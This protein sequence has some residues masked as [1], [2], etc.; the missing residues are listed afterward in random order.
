METRVYLTGAVARLVV[1]SIAAATCC[2]L[3]LSDDMA[4]DAGV[5]S[6]KHSISSASWTS[7]PTLKLSLSFWLAYTHTWLQY[8]HIWLQD[9]QIHISHMA[10]L[11]WLLLLSLSFMYTFH[12]TEYAGSWVQKK[13]QHRLLRLLIWSYLRGHS[14][15]QA[16]IWQGQLPTHI[17]HDWSSTL[18]DQ[19]NLFRDQN[20]V[21]KS[22]PR[23]FWS[24]RSTSNWEASKPH[25]K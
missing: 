22:T 20:C 15:E 16:V 24:C 18:N 23:C 8:H 10:T 21:S 3:L 25:Y 4:D 19:S 6:Q 2:E 7:D 17:S 12:L 14:K 1:T 11:R 9:H 13:D 5:L